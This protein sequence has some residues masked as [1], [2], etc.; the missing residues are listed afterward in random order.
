MGNEKR[1]STFEIRFDVLKI[2]SKRVATKPT[3]IMYGANLS[4]TSFQN[5]IDYLL[6]RGLIRVE[7]RQAKSKT[8]KTYFIT[9]RGAD[10]LNKLNSEVCILSSNIVS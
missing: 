4:W 1:R 9:Q 7:T 2:I 10:V 8:M 5:T 3:R 6:K